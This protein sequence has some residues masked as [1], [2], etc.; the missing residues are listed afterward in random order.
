M[1]LYK[2]SQQFYPWIDS[3]LIA[4]CFLLAMEIR[5]VDMR[6]SPYDVSSLGY[7]PI[8]IETDTGRLEYV[9]FQ[10]MFADKA[11]PIRSR[12]IGALRKLLDA[13]S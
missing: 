9:N 5:E 10:S 6:A 12:L 11:V 13:V 2:W 3:D 1:D 7:A 8:A 4:D